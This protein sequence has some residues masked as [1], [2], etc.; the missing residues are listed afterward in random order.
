MNKEQ[1]KN[2]SQPIPESIETEHLLLK[3]IS[4]DYKG[5]FL[6]NLPQR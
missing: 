5:I 3:T 2:E 4:L 6:R 1:N